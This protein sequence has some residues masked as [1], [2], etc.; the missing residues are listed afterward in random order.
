[1]GVVCCCNGAGAGV[2]HFRSFSG[3]LGGKFSS[4]RRE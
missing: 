4:D 2:G 3:G 1:M